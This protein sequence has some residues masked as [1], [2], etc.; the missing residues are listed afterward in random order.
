MQKPAI[1]DIFV[2]QCRNAQGEVLVTLRRTRDRN[3]PRFDFLDGAGRL[4]LTLVISESG[5]TRAFDGEAHELPCAQTGSAGTY[6]PMTPDCGIRQVGENTVM[7]SCELE[8]RPAWIIDDY[9]NRTRHFIVGCGPDR[10][11]N[12]HLDH[13][14]AITVTEKSR[15]HATL[16]VVRR[17]ATGLLLEDEATVQ[18]GESLEAIARRCGIPLTAL[19]ALNAAVSSSS[20]QSGT[21]LRLA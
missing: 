1:E 21:A 6:G 19:V 4:F 5:A 12:V 11:L 15:D 20:P 17:D 7:I 14:G 2:H 3:D 9:G 16:R 18:P 10:F 8:G 13:R